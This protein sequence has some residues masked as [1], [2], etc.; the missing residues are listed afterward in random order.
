MKIK[1]IIFDWDDVFTIGSK[2]GYFKCYH[3][4][5]KGVGVYL[6]E[7]EEKRRIMAN[8]G[9][10]H[11]EELKGLLKE[12]PH[13]VDKASEIYEENL[14]GGTFV[15]SLH[16]VKGSQDLLSR[17]KGKYLLALATGVH[18]KILEEK[19]MPKFNIP[20]VFAQIITAYDVDDPNK[21]KP[22]P[23]IAQKIMKAQKASP[24]E[25]ILVGDAKSDVEMARNA[26]I[27]PVVVLTGH[28]SRKEAELL[29]V[30][31]ILDDVTQLDEI[32]T[33]LESSS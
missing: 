32:L 27:T 8:W 31:H 7:K 1:L 2:E 5:L 14:F 13:L 23:F 26:D 18:P 10:S 11:Q 15:N 4:A 12:Q 22:H 29:K 30:E 17:L 9:R 6:N 3:K 24:K 25:T 33:D 28:L 21:T 16:I 19:V 20:D